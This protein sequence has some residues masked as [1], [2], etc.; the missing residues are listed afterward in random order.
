MA[1]A[2]GLEPATSGVTGRRYN[3]LNYAPAKG[4]IFACIDASPAVFKFSD[5]T[6]YNKPQPLMTQD[7]LRL[8]VITGFRNTYFFLSRD[9]APAAHHDVFQGDIHTGTP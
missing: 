4:S 7:A 8:H 3:Q 9:F 6:L 1:G 2:T 5:V